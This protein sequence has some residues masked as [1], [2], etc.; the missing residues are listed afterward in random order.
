MISKAQVLMAASLLLF[1]H[2]IVFVPPHLQFINPFYSEFPLPQKILIPKPMK[3]SVDKCIIHLLDL[4]TLMESKNRRSF[5]H[6]W[7]DLSSITTIEAERR[8][9]TYYTNSYRSLNREL[10]NIDL[11]WRSER[12]P[13]PATKTNQ[14]Y[15][16]FHLFHYIGM[17]LPPPESDR[18]WMTGSSPTL[19]D[20]LKPLFSPP[21]VLIFDCH[22]AAILRSFLTSESATDGDNANMCFAFFACS[23]STHIHIES[24]LPQNFFTC[25]ILS[26]QKTF[27]ATTGT[28]ETFLDLLDL[29]TES[30]A[31]DSLPPDVFY[32]LFRWNPLIAVI[33]RRFLLAQR[34]MKKFGLHPES[35]PEIPD[36]SQHHLWHQFEYAIASIGRSQVLPYF[37]GLYQPDFGRSSQ[38]PKYICAFLASLLR[39]GGQRTLILEK[40]A[41]FMRMST[42]NCFTMES[43]LSIDF[44]GNFAAAHAQGESYFQA[45]CTVVSDLFSVAPTL[46]RVSTDNIDL[47]R[48][49]KIVMDESA[50]EITRV[51][52]MSIRVLLKDSQ[53]PFP[54][55]GHSET[56]DQFRINI[57]RKVQDRRNR[58]F[59]WK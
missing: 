30:I 17:G 6:S 15:L 32:Q 14:S 40:I 38:T 54:N 42:A 12:I 18:I 52:M 45:W 56:T 36:L 33:C 29:F 1:F 20:E 44:V 19:L 37:S 25:T 11:T 59:L 49:I 4:P 3:C 9:A 13:R 35:L 26:P 21:S 43:V 46:A 51:L 48:A 24:S 10:F 7:C 58:I 31:L 23:Q 28:S 16:Q 22:C 8:I 2:M 47:V 39:F 27:V 55:R 57:N 53:T 34:L 50:N 41:T 5:L